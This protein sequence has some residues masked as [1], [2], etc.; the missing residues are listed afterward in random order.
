MAAVLAPRQGILL[1]PS[2]SASPYVQPSSLPGTPRL[3]PS[4]SSSSASSS[5]SNSHL[6][7]DADNYFLSVSS[8][9]PSPSAPGSP[10]PSP[11]AH[12]GSFSHPLAL[13]NGGNGAST[14]PHPQKQRTNSNPTAARRIRFAPLPD[15]RREVLVAEDGKEL[16]LPPTF[17]EDGSHNYN[18][19]DTQSPITIASTLGIDSDT[20]MTTSTTLW[21]NTPNGISMVGTA[22]VNSTGDGSKAPSVLNA[23]LHQAA[24]A[25]VAGVDPNISECSLTPTTSNTGARPVNEPSLSRPS[26]RPGSS[27]GSDAK[28]ISTITASS[29]KWSKKLLKPLFSRKT[30]E[31]DDADYPSAD[32]GDGRC[33]RKDE[34][35]KKKDK[36]RS[37]SESRSRKSSSSTLD[38]S[39]RRVESRQPNP[40]DSSGIPLG[41]SQSDSLALKRV[42]SPTAKRKS[43][44]ALLF[45]S[46]T[47]TSLF[48]SKSKEQPLSRSQ[49]LGDTGLGGGLGGLGGSGNVKMGPGGV[50]RGQ[51]RM[52]NGRVYGARRVDPFANVR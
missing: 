38:L 35:G 39:L 24:A 42:T 41:R 14:P 9:S 22:I 12:R 20:R 29:G 25:V 31:N 28:S 19:G 3:A 44:S 2:P 13:H 47:A 48:S 5:T 11:A 45:S 27:H 15:P 6:T 36:Q 4:L 50:R 37:R 43:T 10:L 33:S 30:N 49:S 46:P 34:S 18:A 40:L 17:L 16:P 26:S 52:L 23:E 32:D 21:A 51:L 1:N 7:S 8:H